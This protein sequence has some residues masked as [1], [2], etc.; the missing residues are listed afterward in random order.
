MRNIRVLLF[1]D[2]LSENFQFLEVKFSIY[3]NRCVFV[4]TSPLLCGLQIS[5]S[6][7]DE[8]C[9]LAIPNQTSTISMYTPFGEN[10]PTLTQIIVQKLKCGH[11]ASR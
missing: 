10:P 7:T 6:K 8:I 4:M 5:L 9:I 11:V 2:F 1:L 3:L